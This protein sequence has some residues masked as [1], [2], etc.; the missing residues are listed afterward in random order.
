MTE[1]RSYHIEDE[2]LEKAYD[3]TLMR[4]LMSY[5]MPHKWLTLLTLF[6]L[7]AT[8]ILA[9]LRPWF[10]R[11]AID[12]AIDPENIA[13]A[14]E[15]R[16]AI[17]I[18]LALFFLLAEVMRW[19]MGYFVEYLLLYLGQKIIYAIRLKVFSHLQRLS[20]NYFDKNPVGRL[21][22]RITN[23]VN[24]LDELFSEGLISLFGDLFL[25]L[26]VI[27]I[28]CIVHLQLALITL[29]VIPLLV[30]AAVIFRSL[31]RRTLRVARAKFAAIN[32]FLQENL[33][34]M[35][36]IQ[37]FN[38]EK[39][40]AEQF[41][42]INRAHLDQAFKAVNYFAYMRPVVTV[43]SAVAIGLVLWYGGT[44]VI[45]L[46]PSIKPGILFAFIWWAQ[47]FYR[48][49]LDISEKYN[50][51]Q[52]AMASSERIFKLLDT[53]DEI[54]GAPDAVELGDVRGEIEFKNV[55]FAY[56]EDE[57]VLRDVSFKIH[58]GEGVAFVG[59]TGAGKSSI[60]NLILRFYDVQRGEVLIDGKD[61]RMI[62]KKSLRKHIG[63]VLQDVFIFSGNIASNIRLGD[64]RIALDEVER[65][66]QYVNA[67][68][69]IEWLPG[70]YEAEVK[71]RGSTLS[72][73]QRQLI[74]FARALV[75]DPKILILDEA[76]SNVDTE[77]EMLIRDAIK[78]LIK[79]RTSIIVAHRLSTIQNVDKIIVIH[80]GEIREMGNHQE[81]LKRRGLYYRL[82]QLQYKDQERITAS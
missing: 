63:L 14:V 12:F 10:F 6:L 62:G 50:I 35:K 21:V 44:R 57:Y 19:G 13:I 31:I 81:L 4:R 73:G 54:P 65:S 36:V 46:V 34:G 11:I 2:A 9:V 28:M 51:L 61:V 59:A 68:R 64:E 8:S 30:A 37:L 40:N 24:A 17:L 18:R 1:P 58:P 16:I 38:R 79:G 82:Y 78:K 67:D 15:Q 77:T 48:P 33:M 32:A 29:T 60:V 5:L 70:Q 43:L 45:R 41:H 49:I 66:A 23:D 42:K 71:E 56:N 39:K 53:K 22:T 26:G 80:K 69:F 55:N 27:A 25:I 74:A 72:A 7:L 47:M 52:R 75:H 20:L 3:S 76:T